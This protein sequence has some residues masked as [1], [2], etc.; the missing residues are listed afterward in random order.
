MADQPGIPPSLLEAAAGAFGAAA[1]AGSQELPRALMAGLLPFR[2]ALPPEGWLSESL[3]AIG[4]LKELWEA[5]A[6]CAA[7]AE[8]MKSPAR[9]AQ[10]LS[11]AAD[12]ARLAAYARMC[13]PYAEARG[14]IGP[15]EGPLVS[16]YDGSRMDP[17]AIETALAAPAVGERHRQAFR[18]YASALVRSKGVPFAAAALAVEARPLEPG[19]LWFATVFRELALYLAERKGVDIAYAAAIVRDGFPKNGF[20]HREATL[21]LADFLVDE[22][23]SASAIEPLLSFIR[24]C[25]LLLHPGRTAAFATVLRL[26]KDF[27]RLSR[28]TDERYFG[29]ILKTFLAHPYLDLAEWVGEGARIVR[30]SGGDS[31]EARAFFDRSSEASRKIWEA[32]DVG[33][34]FE[35]AAPRLRPFVT[36]LSG[37]SVSLGKSPDEEGAGHAFMTDGETIFV[38]AYAMYVKD[39]ESNYLMLRHGAAHE[40]AHIEF[41]SFSRDED[42]ARAAASLLAR[43]FPGAIERN[44][45]LAG[46][47]RLRVVKALEKRGYAVNSAGP[48]RRDEF[49]PM[50]RLY[51]MTDY[52]MLYKELVNIVEDR[53]VNVLLYSKYPG[54]AAERSRV[55]EMDLGQLPELSAFPEEARFIQAF[56][57]RLLLGRIKGELSPGDG[58]AVDELVR[59]AEGQDPFGSDVF[60]SAMTAGEALRVIVAHMSARYPKAVAR[61]RAAANRLDI[62]LTALGARPGDRNGL[63]EFELGAAR[64]ASGEAGAADR[65]ARA[66]DTAAF[67]G[68]LRDYGQIVRLAADAGSP[69]FSYPEWA[70]WKLAYERG[71]CLLAELP[72]NFQCP[73][74][75][76]KGRDLRAS[77]AHAADAVRRA[78]ASMKENLDILERGAEDGEDVDFDRAVDCFMDFASG[79][80]VDMDF[81]LRRTR[82]A[83]DLLCAL[84][85]DMSPSTAESVEGRPIF[86]HEVSAAYLMAEAMSAI[87]DAFGIFSYY[88][89][90]ARANVFHVIKDF[91]SPYDASVVDSLDSLRCSDRGFSRMAPG[92]RHIIAKMSASEERAKILFLVTDGQP[93]YVD[94]IRDD[95]EMSTTYSVDGREMISDV[96][97][98]VRTLTTASDEYAYADLRKVAEEAKAAGIRL[99]CVTLDGESVGPL[100]KVFGDSL[101]YLDRV[102][103]LPS[104][105]VEIFRR[106]TR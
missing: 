50:T 15:P 17:A 4:E 12:L 86:E 47:Y 85:L 32:I 91:G 38:P 48:S 105:L 14:R 93:F 46:S 31:N 71:A 72:I 23:Y 19:E 104:R 77:E 89:F 30:V 24:G 22:R 54:Y 69:L 101:I 80:R 65:P 94:S 42:G 53:R 96:P 83:R 60:D 55:D 40:C 67:D 2:A 90:G 28:S 59:L 25:A 37:K 51:F 56:L 11:G 95:G 33:I 100:S 16:P 78:F 35:R 61:M 102:S 9:R 97:L 27:V 34:P 6:A 18:R 58:A 1:F 41:G 63:L 7:S 44:E 98:R 8:A 49:P 57:E 64:K 21:A 36:A 70:D 92:L 82:K 74:F 66:R 29:I 5:A 68:A 106:M 76:E 75:P 62:T 73:E 43:L 52:P 45:A 81:Y 79:G 103:S 13:V 10:E 88:D 87:G 3:A 99:F 26:A 20:A 84:V 39:R